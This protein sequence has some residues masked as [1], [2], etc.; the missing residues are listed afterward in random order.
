MISILLS[1]QV[2]A[3]APAPTPMVDATIV[4]T[5]V[6]TTS[7]APGQAAGT[8]KASRMRMTIH[9]NSIRYDNLEGISAAIPT[10]SPN[11]YALVH[12]GGLTFYTVDTVK[13][14]FSKIDFKA[15]AEE[16]SDAFAAL[17]SLNMSVSDATSEVDS[18][19]PGEAVLGYRTNRWRS[20]QK[21][22]MSASM[23]SDTMA[24]AIEM[25][26]DALYAPDLDSVL[27][28]AA[29]QMSDSL[30]TLGPFA[31]MLPKGLVEKLQ[32][33]QEK[34]PKGMPIRTI[35]KQIVMMGPMDMTTTTTTEITK[36]ERVKHPGSFFAVPSGYKE[37]ESKFPF[38]TPT[39]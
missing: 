31:A 4:E 7:D 35:A 26:S 8:G 12:G 6:T 36:V 37:V 24:M 29:W 13:K 28:A 10:S 17:E 20:I 23:G 14:E 27:A 21:M 39:Q 9:G 38:D 3:A 15:M 30:T 22:T 25:H 11:A 33:T 34:L 1:L 19:G 32:A 18:L 16:M 2:A 5:S